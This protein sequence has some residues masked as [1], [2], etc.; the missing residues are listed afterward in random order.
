MAINDSDGDYARILRRIVDDPDFCRYSPEARLVWLTMLIA[1]EFK[2]LGIA[3]LDP[4][5][6]A[7]RTGYPAPKVMKA[8]VELEL[9]GIIRRDGA[10]CWI[11]NHLRFQ[12]NS[13]AWAKSRQAMMG[14][15]KRL[16]NLPSGLSFLPEF[17]QMYQALGFTFE[18]Q[19]R[20]RA[21]MNILIDKG[22][23]KGPY[24]LI[25]NPEPET[26]ETP[27]PET[28]EPEPTKERLAVVATVPAMPARQQRVMDL[29]QA[30]AMK[31]VACIN[32]TF[33]R[34]LRTSPKVVTRVGE[35]LREQYRPWHI[36][37]LPIMVD[38]Q[39]LPQDMRR[40][41]D[42]LVFLRDGKHARTGADGRTYGATDWLERALGRLDQT[43]L[44]DR[45]ASIAE[46]FAVLTPLMDAGVAIRKASGM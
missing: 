6:V 31:Y 45:L 26:P 12:E 40:T 8:I 46:Q 21:R 9:A 3:T 32:A 25:D 41:L 14:L 23:D 22:I 44:D 39:G 29:V 27:E 30:T 34:N 4:G 17:V 16:A 7:R 2:V 37:A 28:P 24:T 18:L 42:A 11:V 38:A 35:R 19:D 10:W 15:S 5:A 33:G 1:P 36:V 13:E 20:L 43:F